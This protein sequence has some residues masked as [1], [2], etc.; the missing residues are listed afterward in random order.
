MKK[1]VV[2]FI[3]LSILSNITVQAQE[4]FEVADIRVEGL[5]RISAETVFSYLPVGVGDEVD[6]EK[7]RHIIKALFKTGFFR[8]IKLH[9][10]AGVLAITV[11]ERPSIA[12][13]RVTGNKDLD[14]ERIGE[15]LDEEGLIEGRI[16]SEPSLERFVRELNNYYISKGRYG[17]EIETAITPLDQNR[18]DVA[19]QIE[20]GR[21]ARVREIRFVGNS[22]FED[23]VLRRQ[24]V[25]DGNVWTNL[26]FGRNKFSQEKLVLDLESWRN[27]YLDRGI[28]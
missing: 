9:Q 8:D 2:S 20:E 18:V 6:E 4:S 27:F 19:I 14:D 12:A 5:S 23:S 22:A 16:V 21:V 7:S 11:I 13:I 1:I 10:E 24:S 26:L 25:F 15:M 3:L 17:S 28:S